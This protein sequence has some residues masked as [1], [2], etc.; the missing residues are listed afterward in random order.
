MPGI[1][2]ASISNLFNCL[3]IGLFSVGPFVA[4]LL[5][6]SIK[7]GFSYI[8]VFFCVI[9]LFLLL[10]DRFYIRMPTYIILLL[11]F[12]IYT[13]FSDILIVHFPVDVKYF[14]SNLLL[15]SVLI[16]II[17]ENTTI[18]KEFFSAIFTINHIIL[19]IAF[20]VIL[21][22]QFS[23]RTFFV[24][25]KFLQGV[26]SESYSE[27]RL[28][29]IYSWLGNVNAIGLC[30][31]P[32]LAVTIAHHLKNNYKGIFYLFFIGAVVAFFSKSRFNM[33]NY[34]A[35]F[36]L[37]PIYRGWHL[38]TFFKY[39][40]LLAAGV[41]ALYHASKAVGLNTDKIVNERILEKDKGGLRTGSAG[42]RILAFKIFNRLYFEHPI[43][44]KGYFHR[45][46]NKN[47]DY[48]LLHALRGRSSQIHVGYLSLFYYYGLFGG[49]IYLLFLWALSR[50]TYKSA[51]MTK[52][53][54]PFFA[55]LQFVLTNL[56]G[57]VFDLFIMGMVMAVFYYRYYSQID[58]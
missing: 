14:Y 48:E 22:Q 10:A 27:T 8:M 40:F 25:P 57:V 53:W 55:I 30:F 45:S 31:F 54:G 34:M 17:I 44:G 52:Q 11:C 16:F 58:A 1:K 4:W 42:T 35:L 7:S 24:D 38:G 6:H 46:D 43:F 33:L 49:L 36:L 20:V 19:F 47:K 5:S 29:S 32:I 37:I 13:I 56:T 18:S 28:S 26:L 12:L 21:I 41:F 2:N 23:D 51:R 39:T 15:G 50:E 3:I 9:A